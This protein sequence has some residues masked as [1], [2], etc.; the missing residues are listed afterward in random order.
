MPE[1]K[2]YVGAKLIRAYRQSHEDGR[3]G[4]VVIYPDGYE[5]WSPKET[6]ETAYREVTSAEKALVAEG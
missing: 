6:F 3:D 4:Y 1:I 5:S 2:A